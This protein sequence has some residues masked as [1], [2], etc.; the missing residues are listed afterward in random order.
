MSGYAVE[1][2]V[3]RGEIQTRKNICVCGIVIGHSDVLCRL[4]REEVN[5]LGYSTK[6][7]Q[8]KIR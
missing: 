6:I 1:K 4:C 3:E 7:Q 8:E 5:L 2:H